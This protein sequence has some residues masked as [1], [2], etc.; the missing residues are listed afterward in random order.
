MYSPADS[1]VGLNKR[2]KE[3]E[4]LSILVSV[5]FHLAGSIDKMET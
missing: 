1:D 5:T 3:K 2:R 4:V